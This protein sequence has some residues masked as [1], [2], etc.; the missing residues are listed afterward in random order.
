LAE[1]RYQLFEGSKEETWAL[2]QDLAGGFLMLVPVEYRPGQDRL[3][4]AE[5]DIPNY[6]HGKPGA[7]A[8]RRHAQSALA[9]LGWISKPQSIPGLPIG[10]APSTHVEVVAPEDVD[11]MSVTLDARQYRPASNDVAQSRRTIYNKPRTVVNVS[12]L[13]SFART[14]GPDE[15]RDIL[16]A[17]SDEATVEVRFRTPPHGVIMAATAV[18][19]PLTIL[20]WFAAANLG[21]V[22]ARR[23]R[24]CCSSSRR[25]LPRT[26]YDPASTPSPGVCSRACACAG[27]A[28]RSARC[29]SPR[30]WACGRSPSRW[31]SGLLRARHPRRRSAVDC[32]AHTGPC[33]ARFPR[34]RRSPAR[35]PSSAPCPAP[36]G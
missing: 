19:V 35:G 29:S 1:R 31:P 32:R 36:G 22:I 9:S 25:S 16:K 27:S 34:C 13:V 28:S 15:E 14:P 7:D 10:W 11:V 4:K 23:S 30:C 24:P 6:W 12:P 2:L 17:R 5:W 20:V 33:A 21:T 18:A 26:S 3:L 8:F